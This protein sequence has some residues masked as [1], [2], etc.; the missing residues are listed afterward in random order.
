MTAVVDVIL[1]KAVAGLSIFW[2]NDEIETF[3]RDYKIGDSTV[4]FNHVLAVLFL[5]LWNVLRQPVSF[6]WDCWNTNPIRI[7][8]LMP[9][10]Y[11]DTIQK[12]ARKYL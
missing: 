12:R 4:G 9:E 2:Q 11:L 6:P 8:T 1:I 3:R 5:E 7:R 10:L